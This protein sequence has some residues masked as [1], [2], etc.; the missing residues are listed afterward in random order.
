[1]YYVIYIGV[2]L[3]YCGKSLALFLT[4]DNITYDEDSL[5]IILI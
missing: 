2:Y 1:M 5:I 4:F 3:T